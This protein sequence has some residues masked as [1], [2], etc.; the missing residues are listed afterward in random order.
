MKE[1][2]EQEAVFTWAKYSYARYP[3]LEW[4]MFA[5][6]NGGTR[7]KL[8]AYSL[9]KQGVKSGV[10]DITIQ[11]PRG[12]YHGFWLELKTDKGKTS[13]NQE[14]FLNEM[15]KQGYY[16]KVCWG[17]ESAINAIIKYMNLKGREGLI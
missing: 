13:E 2:Y 10:S 4:A 6:P 15:K 3:E 5:I 17:A 8:E 12:K 9:K 11:V 16:T 1:K 14:V 7:H